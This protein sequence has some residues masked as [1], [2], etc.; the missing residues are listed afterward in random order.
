M[1][2]DSKLTEFREKSV[3]LL[4]EIDELKTKYDGIDPAAVATDRAK[5]AEFEKAKAHERVT[6]IVAR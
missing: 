6:A 4:K 1:A 2:D 3:A 5:L